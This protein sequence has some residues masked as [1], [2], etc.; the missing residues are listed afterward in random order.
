MPYI[1]SGI[2]SGKY[3][4]TDIIERKKR[5]TVNSLQYISSQYLIV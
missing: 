1:L 3:K 4:I 2:C 5:N